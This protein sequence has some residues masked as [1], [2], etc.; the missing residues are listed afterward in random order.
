[1]PA[2]SAWL[3]ALSYSIKCCSDV[4]RKEIGNG[5]LGLA[6]NFHLS[7]SQHILDCLHF[8]VTS[9]KTP[10]VPF[11]TPSTKVPARLMHEKRPGWSHIIHLTHGKTCCHWK[12][13]SRMAQVRDPW[14]VA[15]AETDFLTIH[16]VEVIWYAQRISKVCLPVFG[17][18]IFWKAKSVIPPRLDVE[19]ISHVSLSRSVKEIKMLVFSWW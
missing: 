3:L 1:M 8:C 5:P 9:A 17:R 4:T 16:F 11:V 15:L 6:F 19:N 12:I 14:S 18:H 7:S 10:T 13:V 2:T